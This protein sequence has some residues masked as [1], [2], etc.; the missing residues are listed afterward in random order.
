[1]AEISLCDV[2]TLTSLIIPLFLAGRSILS[3]WRHWSLV[4]EPR[5]GRLL[6]AGEG[7]QEKLGQ[8]NCWWGCLCY[9]W[10]KSHCPSVP[11]HTNQV[12]DAEPHHWAGYSLTLLTPTLCPSLSLLLSFSPLPCSL[13][14]CEL[15]GYFIQHRLHNSH[16][17]F[18]G[19]EHRRQTE[20]KINSEAILQYSVG[21]MLL[22]KKRCRYHSKQI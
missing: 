11:R 20:L 15:I 21:A 9:H 14:S 1:M 3:F 10:G 13:C 8:V 17:S 5:H 6:W 18:V 12:R 22:R 7:G 16:L 19:L 4:I 2:T